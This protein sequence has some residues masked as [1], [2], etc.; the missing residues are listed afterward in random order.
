MYVVTSAFLDALKA[1]SMTA[2]VQV[3]A[4]N[5][6]TLY[7]TSGSVSMDSRRGITRTCDLELAPTPD[8]DRQALYA[9]LTTPSMEI[10]VSRGLMVNGVA[11]YVPLGVFS[12]DSARKT[13]WGVSWQGSDRAKK[14]SRARFTDT[15]GIPSG[16]ALADAM[17][18][19]LQSRWSYTPVDFTNVTDTLSAGVTFDAGES[20][21]PWAQAQS[22][23]AD[24]GYWLTFDGT[25]T[26][27]AVP[28]PDPASVPATFDCGVGET[29]LVTDGE[30]VGTFENTYNGVIATGEGSQVDTPVR[31]EAWDDD[32]TSPTYY[33]GG[34]GLVPRFYS[35]PVLTTTAM[36]ALAAQ[37]ILARGKGRT[38]QFSANAVVNPALEPMDVVTATL[39][40]ESVRLVI[41]K[42]TIPLRAAEAMQIVGRETTV[43]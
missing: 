30:T 20:S 40:G 42:L 4:S 26:A 33:L 27:V 1:P 12:T 25:G 19:L 5:G 43:G 24:F 36:C 23:M 22:L 7:A 37:T 31:A 11:E 35:S 13:K 41:D 16:T 18:E 29:N 21:D 15:Y 2:V 39:Y 6:A 8:Y 38:E 10:T 32:P 9:L 28:V 17:T 34:F 14:I 3:V